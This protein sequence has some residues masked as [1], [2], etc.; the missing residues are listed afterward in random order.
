MPAASELHALGDSGRLAHLYY[1]THKYLAL[2]GVPIVAYIVFVSR[3]FVEL[4]V[5]PSLSV[6]AVPLS[7]LLIVNFVNLT[8]GPGLLILVGRG[9][10]RPGL[11]SAAFG[12]VLNATLSLFLIRAYGFP[13]AVIGT[14]LSV[15]IAS[16]FFLYLF[17]RETGQA[18]PKVFRMAYPKP[19]VCALAGIAALWILTH[20][21]RSSWGK[22]LANCVVFGF[23]YLFLLLLLRFFD[24]SDLAM[25]ER[26]LPI[27]EIVRRIIPD[28]ELG[29]SLLSDSEGA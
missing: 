26:F 11:R 27:P 24:R 29:S 18:F 25:V 9:N 12:I 5:G 4:W 7:V 15:I 1:R 17:R 20:S 13:G 21:E 22:L 3:D 23:V 19:I 16:G 10:L 6:I 2:L 14:S 28:A 8:T